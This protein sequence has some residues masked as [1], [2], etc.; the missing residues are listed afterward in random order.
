MGSIEIFPNSLKNFFLVQR[1]VLVLTNRQNFPGTHLN[2][3]TATITFIS[4]NGD[5]I[6][7]RSVFIAIICS[8]NYYF[9]III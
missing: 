4:V 6:F 3:L 1:I 5:E 7:T 8:H 9:L 2:A